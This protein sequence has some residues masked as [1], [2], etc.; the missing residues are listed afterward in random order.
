[1]LLSM[2]GRSQFVPITAG[3]QP[4]ASTTAADK[5]TPWLIDSTM[6]VIPQWVQARE[7]IAGNNLVVPTTG[8]IQTIVNEAVSDLGRTIG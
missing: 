3:E 5:V 8:I 2:A 6:R 4:S 7:A 1:V